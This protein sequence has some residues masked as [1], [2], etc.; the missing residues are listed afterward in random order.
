M[1]R[2]TAFLALFLLVGAV[3]FSSC[4]KE[5]LSSKKEILS[6]IFE[7]S[8]NPQLDRNY[9]GDINGTAVSAEVAFGVSTNQLIP[10]IEISPR[11]TLS[12]K[13]GQLTD[14]SG[15][16]VYTVTAEDG[17]TKTF[18]ATVVTAPA[19]YIGSWVSG[20]IDFGSG[21]MRVNADITAAG[22]IKLE[23][24]QIMTGDKDPSSM[25]GFFEPLSR[26][27]TEIKVEQTHRWFNSDWVGETC[28]RTF[29]YHVNTP[30]NIKL[31]YCLC[32]PMTDWC[33][34]VNLSKE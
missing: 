33:F 10:T 31:Y 13:A 20:P 17:S 24:T 16:V 34:Q 7:A 4:K 29:M 30:Q 8:K 19:P 6:L 15:P 3:F 21:L 14:F 12:P 9:L 11:A 1:V 22:D 25:K 26:Q 32:Y 2:K 18:T 27:D 28:N 23:F 5:E